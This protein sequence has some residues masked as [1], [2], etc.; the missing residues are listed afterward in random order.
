MFN[1]VVEKL[2]ILNDMTAVNK[3]WLLL[4][5]CVLFG[6]FFLIALIKRE[7][8]W[9]FPTSCCILMLALCVTGGAYSGYCVYKEPTAIALQVSANVEDVTIEDISQYF[10]CSEIVFG[11]GTFVCVVEPKRDYFNDDKSYWRDANMWLEEKGIK[12]EATDWSF[13]KLRI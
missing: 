2:N 10:D 13:W 8:F 9:Q 1:E 4:E 12:K 11:D 3:M 5:I 6:A 7:K